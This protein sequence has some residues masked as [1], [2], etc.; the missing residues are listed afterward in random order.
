VHRVRLELVAGR[1]AL[2]NQ[3]RGLLTEFGIVMPKGR[4]LM[5]AHVGDALEH[6]DLPELART[7]LGEL[8]WAVLA[9]G[10][11]TIRDADSRPSRW[12]QTSPAAAY[13]LNPETLDRGERFRTLLIHFV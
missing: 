13:S 11:L 2:I 1:T 5:R 3:L 7:V 10:N 8:V 9:T 12:T 4:Y 6:H